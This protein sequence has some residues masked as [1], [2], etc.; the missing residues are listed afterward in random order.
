MMVNQIRAKNGIPY[1]S[2]SY[3]NAL[4]LFESLSSSDHYPIPWS[5][6]LWVTALFGVLAL[7]WIYRGQ[8]GAA[9]FGLGLMIGPRFPI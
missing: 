3:E 6:A 7:W 5:V 4:V 9:W 8:A 2:L 1:D